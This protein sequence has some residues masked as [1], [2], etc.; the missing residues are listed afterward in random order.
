[1]KNESRRSWHEF[2]GIFGQ[3]LCYLC[4]LNFVDT[5]PQ[6]TKAGPQ[7]MDWVAGHIHRDGVQNCLPQQ[8]QQHEEGSNNNEGANCMECSRHVK[9]LSVQYI[10]LF[11]TRIYF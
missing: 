2:H 3:L 4:S 6:L 1:M 9:P 7:M 5:G 10:S 8:R 11:F